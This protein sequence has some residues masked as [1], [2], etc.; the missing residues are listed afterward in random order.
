MTHT[1]THTHTSSCILEI[2]L[3]MTHIYTHPYPCPRL[4][5]LHNTI[6]FHVYRSVSLARMRCYMQIAYLFH[7]CATS[8]LSRDSRIAD[9]TVRHPGVERPFSS[10]SC[11]VW[12]HIKQNIWA[13]TNGWT[14]SCYG[15]S[16][17]GFR[18]CDGFIW[19]YLRF[20]GCD[21]FAGGYLTCGFSGL[22]SLPDDLVFFVGGLI[23]FNA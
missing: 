3:M 14:L 2:C 13:L 15:L 11:S 10:L 12:L 1:H 22:L 5:A 7:Q 18:G 6:L 16:F 19:K 8:L 20:I 17:W 4:I 23:V 21:G 9:C